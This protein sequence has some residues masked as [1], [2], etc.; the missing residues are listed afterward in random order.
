VKPS[1][2]ALAHERF[3]RVVQRGLE[4]ADR[5]LAQHMARIRALPPLAREDD[6]VGD[7]RQP[8]GRRPL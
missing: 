8:K 2:P 4:R 5:E 6:G 1:D 7:L 3:H